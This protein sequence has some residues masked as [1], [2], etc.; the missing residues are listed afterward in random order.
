MVGPLGNI[1]KFEPNHREPEKLNFPMNPLGKYMH[2]LLILA[3]LQ[4][5]D[6][7]NMKSE[8]HKQKNQEKTWEGSAQN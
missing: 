4:N 3:F 6:R 1:K 5:L 2:M 8:K 7:K